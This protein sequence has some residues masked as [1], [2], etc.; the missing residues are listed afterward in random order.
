V[1]DILR[2][3]TSITAAFDNGVREVIPV[4]RVDEARAYKEKGFLVASE[5]EG[6]TLDFADFGNS[7]FN[8][9]IPEVR[10]KT[11]AYS[12]TN[13]TQSIALAQKDAEEVALG[14]FNNLS[15]VARWLEQQQKNVVVLCSGYK[16]TFNIEDSLF[17]GA[18]AQKLMSVGFNNAGSDAVTIALDMWADAKSDPLAYI[19]KAAHIKRLRQRRQD[20]VLPF[21]FTIDNSKSVPVLRKSDSRLYDAGL[22]L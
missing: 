3:T 19:K 12:T 1:V 21:T 4:A 18:L 20:D 7:A 2:A 14:A 9:M 6:K 17:A 13:G 15:A 8:F 10:G 22:N 16:N 11:I 5:R